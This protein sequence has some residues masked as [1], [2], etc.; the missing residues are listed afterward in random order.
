MYVYYRCFWDPVSCVATVIT[1]THDVQNIT[2]SSPQPG[3]VTVTGDIVKGSNVTDLVLYIFSVATERFYYHH[4]H[5]TVQDHS[6]LNFSIPVR[7]EGVYYLW[8]GTL[9]NKTLSERPATSAIPVNATS[10]E[11]I[12]PGKLHS[13]SRRNRVLIPYFLNFR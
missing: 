13:G 9:V 4:Y 6:M 1:G 10:L 12:E 11:I 5:L 2:A 7:H 3:V 8:L